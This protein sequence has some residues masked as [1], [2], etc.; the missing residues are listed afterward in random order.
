MILL[1]DKATRAELG[2][3]SE[4]ELQFLIDQLE[5]EALDDRDYYI[6]RAT[7]DLFETAGASSHLIEL[8][9]R[10]LGDRTDVEVEWLDTANPD[11]LP[12]PD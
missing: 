5:E 10:A 7:V 4:S 1:L 6:N 8:L 9:N 11:R 2:E 12:V 3:I